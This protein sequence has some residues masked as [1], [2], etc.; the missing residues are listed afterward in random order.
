MKEELDYVLALFGQIAKK[1]DNF[2]AGLAQLIKKTDVDLESLTLGDFMRLV[3]AYTAA[4]KNESAVKVPLFDTPSTE[5]R[6]LSGYG[7][8][9]EKVAMIAQLLGE[10]AKQLN[11]KRKDLD[12]AVCLSKIYLDNGKS[13]ATA[14]MHGYKILTKCNALEAVQ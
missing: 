7:T 8:H 10:R 6:L 4:V 9:Q 2:R 13:G 1:P 14:L 11:I 5:S 12:S 3:S